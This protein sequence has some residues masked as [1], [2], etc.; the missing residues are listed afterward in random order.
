MADAGLAGCPTNEGARGEGVNSV[1]GGDGR[2]VGVVVDGLGWQISK[3]SVDN[4][5]GEKKGEGEKTRGLR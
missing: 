5:M 4:G 1:Q 2:L 3:D